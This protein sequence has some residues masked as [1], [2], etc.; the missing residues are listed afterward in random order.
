MKLRLISVIL[1]I[2][3]LSGCGWFG[4]HEPL[5]IADNKLPYWL[6]LNA[7]TTDELNLVVIHA[8]ELSDMA[9]AREYGER[10]LYESGTGASGHYYIDRDGSIEQYVPD[11]RIANHTSGWNSRSLSIELVNK[12]RYPDWY[13]SD[14]Q[15][16]L[17]PYPKAQINALIKLVR[18]LESKYPSLKY[19]QGHED[20]DTR[21][22]PAED[23]PN[24]EIHRKLDPGPYFPWARF[25]AAINLKKEMP[26]KDE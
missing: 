9:E 15:V 23:N 17:E 5:D 16:M 21:M 26:P 13:K 6:K 20:L 12:G 11:N 14:H 18:E 24:I 7:R 3:S 22:M 8:T 25:L 10:I 19:V 1:A 2:L 4:Y